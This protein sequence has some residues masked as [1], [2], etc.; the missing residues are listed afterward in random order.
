MKKLNQLFLLFLGLMVVSCVDNQDEEYL[1]DAGTKTI[2]AGSREVKINLDSKY[3]LT[4]T[5]A[6]GL[7]DTMAMNVQNRTLAVPHGAS[8]MVMFMDKN[9]DKILAVVKVGSNETQLNVNAENVTAALHDIL[10]GYASLS[11][12][13]RQH[14]DHSAPSAPAYRSLITSVDKILSSKEGIYSTNSEL[15][16][17]LRAMNSFIAENYS[18]QNSGDASQRVAQDMSQWIQ[19]G[20]TPEINNRSYGYVEARFTPNRDDKGKETHSFILNPRHVYPNQYSLTEI[21]V[22]DGYYT[23]TLT[24]K[25]SAARQ[26]NQMGLANNLLFLTIGDS[27]N[28]LQR[29]G[30]EECATNMVTSMY[31]ELDKLN[32]NPPVDMDDAF[33]KAL[34]ISARMTQEL[35]TSST[36]ERFV[37]NNRALIATI[38]QR[39]LL[40]AATLDGPT[41]LQ[42]G[43]G[44]IFLLEAIYMPFEFEENLMIH[45]N[46]VVPG[47]LRFEMVSSS[48][49]KEYP[50]KASLNPEV[51]AVILSQYDEID[52]T[53]F[54]V[55][56]ETRY[57]N[58]GTV[59]EST[60]YF[61]AEG[62][63]TTTWTLPDRRTDNYLNAF[64]TDRE[65]DHLMGSSMCF[66]VSTRRL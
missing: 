18:T 31:A 60:T 8:D 53:I 19:S 12:E 22:P 1:I 21:D 26:A 2:P 40:L 11:V 27:F 50:R 14:F 5:I 6:Y 15:V 4:N 43:A 51:R 7:Y 16:N 55:D 41:L 36:C 58:N 33:L 56:W 52:F 13:D 48:Y 9:S 17:N 30:A 47:Q 45:Q 10:P 35:L 65:G 64:V 54:S 62:I 49:D 39:A 24:Q 38:A 34:T 3:D 37:N 44:F 23:L 42:E 25:S 46:K 20:E 29:Q 57:A 63:A 59:S 28:M 61:N 66:V 32:A